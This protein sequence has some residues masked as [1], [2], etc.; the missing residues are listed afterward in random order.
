[1]ITL[2][3][4]VESSAT[5]THDAVIPVGTQVGDLLIF[6][7][8]FSSPSTITSITGWTLLE[9]MDDD[10]GRT[11]LSVFYKEATES[12]TNFTYSTSGSPLSNT[13]VAC[14][15]RRYGLPV[16]AMA[17]GDAFADPPSLNTGF[18]G[19]YSL[20]LTAA[21]LD[22]AVV[23]EDYPIGYSYNRTVLN[24]TNLTLGF[25]AKLSRQSIEDPS[26]FLTDSGD[27]WVAATIG[28]KVSPLKVLIKR[29]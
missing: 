19:Y 4:S 20:Y 17:N 29:N 23:I 22:G 16:I 18:V 14:I 10:L 5:S 2:G 3:T 7:A 26:M 15:K 9:E 24:N 28:I 27:F 12:E 6:I 13:I 11:S 21:I 8:G 1:M 25:A